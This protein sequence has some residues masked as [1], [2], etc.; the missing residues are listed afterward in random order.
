MNI[1]V[2][3]KQVIDTGA[4]IEIRDGQVDTE[5]SPRVLNPYDEFAV[6][7]A[8]RIKQK[9]PETTITLI[10]LGPDNFKDTLKRG[11]AMGA[12]QAVHLL[13]PAFENIDPLGVAYVLAKAIR[14]LKFDLIIFRTAFSNRNIRVLSSFLTW[15]EE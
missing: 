1:I 12:D 15:S 7:E 4:T 6:E 14:I 10:S 5:A 8:V 13:D 9:D 11:L 2:C 3:V